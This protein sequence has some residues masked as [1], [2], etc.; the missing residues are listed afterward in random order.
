MNDAFNLDEFALAEQIGKDAI[1][2]ARH[3]PGGAE[4]AVVHLNMARVYAATE[5][6]ALY[7]QHIELA[8]RC[9]A[10]GGNAAVATVVDSFQAM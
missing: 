6:L 9:T 4:A 7:E 3:L 1:A 5:R 10:A 8:A 2:I